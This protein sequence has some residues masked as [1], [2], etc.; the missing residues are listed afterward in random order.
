MPPTA[1][2]IGAVLLAL[3]AVGLFVFAVRRMLRREQE[4][5]AAM[6]ERYDERLAGFAQTL[7]DALASQQQPA[8]DAT[9]DGPGPLD[10]HNVLLRTLEVAAARTSA[11]AAIAVLAASNGGPPTIA[12]IRLSHEETASVARIGFPDYR[13][14]RALQVSFNAETPPPAGAEP[15]RSGLFISLLGEQAPPSMVAVLT[16]ASE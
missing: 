12:T 7:H 14:A 8:L 2:Y 15:I 1:I 9:I 13:D 16:R 5:V 6:L 3:A 10:T 4:V 11:D